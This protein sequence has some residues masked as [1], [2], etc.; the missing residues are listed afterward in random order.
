MTSHSTP[1]SSSSSRETVIVQASLD[2]KVHAVFARGQF[3]G[4]YRSYLAHAGDIGPL[5]DKGALRLMR[6]TLAA[7]TLQLALLPPDQYCSWTFNIEK[8]RLN[9]FVAGDNNDFQITGRVHRENVKTVGTSRLFFES[10]RPNHKPAQ[11]VVD[12]DGLDVIE[13]FR[14]YYRRSLQTRATIFE[15]AQDDVLLVQGLPNVD[16]D[17][18]HELDAES[19]RSMVEGG[20]EPIEQRSYSFACGC[21]IEKITLAV[22]KMFS[23]RI[24]ELFEGQ[25]TVDIQ[26]PRCGRAWSLL[27]NDIEAGQ[28]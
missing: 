25:D 22:R 23:G 24:D 3:E 2:R 5:P 7:A 16:V 8:L 11:S 26:C 20:I 15:L 6:K 27:R 1:L 18:F 13:A 21:D 10:Q 17:W 12:F 4:I 9:V 14:E 19:A 28:A